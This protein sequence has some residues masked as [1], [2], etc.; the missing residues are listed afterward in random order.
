MLPLQ[1]L[2]VLKI[3]SIAAETT[4]NAAKEEL[5]ETSLK[6][7]HR[8]RHYRPSFDQDSTEADQSENGASSDDEESDQ[9]NDIS[10]SSQ[11]D[12]RQSVET[13]QDRESE[14]VETQRQEENPHGNHANEDKNE[15]HDELRDGLE[16]L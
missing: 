5:P 10:K 1:F 16:G 3:Y 12:T 7:R 14:D 15:R 9:S 2:L 13:V 4:E 6:H 11:S 8:S